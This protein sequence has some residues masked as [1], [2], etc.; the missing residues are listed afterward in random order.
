MPGVMKLTHANPM[1]DVLLSADKRAGVVDTWDTRINSVAARVA[2][3]KANPQAW[4]ADALEEDI[5]GRPEWR[6]AFREDIRG[7]TMADL[8]RPKLRPESQMFLG[9]MSNMGLAALST[10]GATAP[11]TNVMTKAERIAAANQQNGI[12]L[13]EARNLEAASQMFQQYKTLP[14]HPRAPR[15][16]MER[17]IA[18]TLVQGIPEGFHPDSAGISVFL[19]HGPKSEGNALRALLLGAGK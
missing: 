5:I 18:E 3:F 16:A 13:Q 2:E 12:I 14:A 19:G 9:N 6:A 1:D 4:I 15:A 8:G 10:M 11:A 7:S 17:Q